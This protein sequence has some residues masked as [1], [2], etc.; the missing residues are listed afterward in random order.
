MR[1]EGGLNNCNTH[2]VRDLDRGWRLERTC[3]PGIDSVRNGN[4]VSEFALLSFPFASLPSKDRTTIGVGLQPVSQSS[5]I[6][7]LVRIM[8]GQQV[9]NAGVNFDKLL[10]Q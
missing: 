8:L 3:G 2:P 7:L 4:R 6:G 10:H 9:S 1:D 5:G